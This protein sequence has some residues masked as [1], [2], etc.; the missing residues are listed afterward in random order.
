MN[1]Q[2]PKTQ[3]K[4]RTNGGNESVRGNPLRD[5]PERLEEFTESCG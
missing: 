3:I 2:K 4:M 1:Q 5:L